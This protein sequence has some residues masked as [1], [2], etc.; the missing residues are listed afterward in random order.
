MDLFAYLSSLPYLAYGVLLTGLDFV[1][2][3]IINNNSKK[4]MDTSV[5]FLFIVWEK[6][7]AHGE[8]LYNED[9]NLIII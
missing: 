5:S 6:E 7:K 1:M 4:V 2:L 8:T 3:V 9:K